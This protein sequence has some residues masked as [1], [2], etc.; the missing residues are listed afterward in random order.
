[1]AP[2]QWEYIGLQAHSNALQSLVER[3]NDAGAR[4]WELISVTNND[5]TIGANAVLAMLRR[6]IEPLA[7]PDQTDPGWK[8]D[9]SSRF[10]ERFWDGEA[11]TM[12]TRTA[13]TEHR[14]PPTS[15]TPAQ[16]R[17]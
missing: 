1:M 5:P 4:G 15:R 10:E 9:P 16:V 8:G 17:Q 3:L 12:R 13:A 6:P 11:W 14:D 7:D 2:T